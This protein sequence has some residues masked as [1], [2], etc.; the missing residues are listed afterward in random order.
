MITTKF[1]LL[2]AALALGLPVATAAFPG[3]AE[4]R[5]TPPAQV[6]QAG[7]TAAPT[8]RPARPQRRQSAQAQQR[9][10]RQPASQRPRRAITPNP[11]P[12]QERP[13]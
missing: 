2:L 1:R 4:A 11:T 6:A 13:G 12:T 7:D 9:R 8:A 10:M 3:Q 5:S